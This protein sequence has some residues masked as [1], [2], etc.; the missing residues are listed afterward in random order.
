M[1]HY[2]FINEANKNEYT[3]KQFFGLIFE[4]FVAE[5][6]EL[7]VILP[8]GATDIKVNLGDLNIILYFP[9]PSYHSM[10]MINTILLLIHI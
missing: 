6:Y 7:K 3:L 1:H 4:D 8:E 10:L 5:E 2:L 9:S